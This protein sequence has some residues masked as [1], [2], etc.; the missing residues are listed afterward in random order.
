MATMIAEVYD[1][2]LEAGATPGK[3][4]A[5]AEALAGYESRFTK[6]EQQITELRGRVDLLTWMVGFNL[7]L[8]TGVLFKLFSS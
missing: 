5:A 8:T 3:A 6:I 7:V 2:F 1:A 4:R